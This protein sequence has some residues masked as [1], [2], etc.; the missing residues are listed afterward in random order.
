[1]RGCRTRSCLP[2]G[3][4]EEAL[5]S[6]LSSFQTR[7]GGGRALGVLQDGACAGSRGWPRRVPPPRARAAGSP[8]GP[9]PAGRS[10][11]LEAPRAAS[12]TLPALEA[13]AGCLAPRLPGPQGGAREATAKGLRLPR[14]VRAAPRLRAPG[15]G[16]RPLCPAA[17]L[18]PAAA[19]PARTTAAFIFLNYIGG[20]T[21]AKT[22]ER[23]AR[24]ERAGSA[25]A[26]PEPGAAAA[27]GRLRAGAPRAAVRQSRSPPSSAS[28]AARSAAALLV[29]FW[30]E[31][32]GSGLA[33]ESPPRRDPGSRR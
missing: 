25:G 32:V 7:A 29:G 2:R 16:L 9:S 24:P 28:R 13:A 15:S 6:A 21:K 10:R 26:G 3:P 12:R 20:K 11:A 17:P 5:R 27:S 4:G 30:P 19:A 8:P 33:A 23:R 1:M 14:R 31:R 18:A 22:A